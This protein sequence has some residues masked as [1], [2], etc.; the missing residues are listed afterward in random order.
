M[1]NKL[2]SIILPVYNVEKYIHRSVESLL[3]QTIAN[4]GDFEIILVDDGST[5]S[6]GEI[7]DAYAQKYPSVVRTVR[8]KNGGV[9]TARN[10]G[11]DI[12][13]GEWI[14]FVDPDDYVDLDMYEFLYH[15]AKETN[16]E[17]AACS[18][19]G[20][21]ANKIIP[22]NGTRYH[23]TVSKEIAITRE[24][25]DN[26]Y[27]SCNKIFYYKCVENIH[28]KV[29][30]INGEDRLFDLQAICQANKVTY[31]FEDK[32][33]YCHRVNSA[34]TKNFTSADYKLLDICEEIAQIFK[35]YVPDSLDVAHK[36]IVLAYRQLLNMMDFSVTKY[37]PYSNH[38]LSAL[39]K[40]W[41]DYIIKNTEFSLAEK[42]KFSLLT[43]HPNLFKIV[44]RIAG[45]NKEERKLLT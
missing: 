16:A 10:A 5:D 36:Q 4:I 44:R 35:N 42:M 14:G 3:R 13:Q 41:F 23:D 29:D 43:I 32:Y 33:N 6:S 2:L 17:I 18:W 25:G 12:A 30:C 38:I 34:G 15:V 45:V 37:S 24:I 27:L 40:H 28:Y 11:L 26:I 21:Y 9:S 20:V 7:C 22:F 39:R 31:R 19:R 8:K 1:R